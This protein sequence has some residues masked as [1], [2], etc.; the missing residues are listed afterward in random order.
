MA[1]VL[2]AL[3]WFAYF[4]LHSLLADTRTKQ[5]VEQ[6]WPGF[7]PGYR[8]AYNVLALLLLIP[9]LVLVYG[10]DR[11][12]LWQ[13]TGATAWLANGLTTASLVLFLTVS[14]AYAMDEFL[15]LRQWRERTG[16]DGQAF[17]ISVLHRFVRHPWYSLGLILLWTRDMNPPL[18]VSA[19]A[20]TV[21]LIVGSRLEERS[22]V[23]RFGE[24]YRRYMERV[25]GLVPLPWKFLSTSDAERL[26]HPATPDQE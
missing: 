17:T 6:R 21:Y 13:W 11:D 5:R 2:L 18:L 7:M 15:G 12:W 25:P 16:D 23:M 8:L 9:I 10:S 14:R 26:M 3:A 1:E 20:I 24:A 19:L 4:A 22:L